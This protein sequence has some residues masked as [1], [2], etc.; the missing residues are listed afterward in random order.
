MHILIGS[1]GV[2]I[3]GMKLLAFLAWNLRGTNK[4]VSLTVIN[5]EP[6]PSSHIIF[7]FF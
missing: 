2:V 1:V 7:F 5:N 3:G 4:A 6:P